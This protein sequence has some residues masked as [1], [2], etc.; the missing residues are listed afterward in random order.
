MADETVKETKAPEMTEE[1]IVGQLPDMQLAQLRFE[2]GCSD[3]VCTNKA[4]LK[5][6]LVDAVT[7]DN[8]TPFYE[9]MCAE[10][11]WS[12]DAALV[13]AA[14]ASNDVE[15][16][17]IDD[18][19][20]DAEENLGDTEVLDALF[21]KCKYFT[22]IGDKDGALASYATILTKADM[23]SEEKG[24]VK[25]STSQRIQIALNKLRLGMFHSDS[26]L[27]KQE[28]PKAKQLVELG[29]DWDRRNRLQVYE[30]VAMMTQRDFKG[31]C[32]LFSKSVATF[33]CTELM[34]FEQLVLYT[35]VTGILSLSRVELQE[36]VVECAEVRSTAGNIPFLNDLMNGIYECR[37]KAFFQA[38]VNIDNSLILNRYLSRH[39]KYIVR[40]FRVLAYSQ[41]LESYRS[42]TLA[43]SAKAF[44]VSIEFLD[45]ELARFIA[46]GRLNAKIDKC[47][48]IVETNRPDA[49]NAQYQA[50]IKQGDLLLNRIQKLAR[51]VNV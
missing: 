7:K 22:R 24:N 44:G 37:Y 2:L 6:Q 48:G 12:V 14:K 51:A 50:M 36:K 1:E 25:L 20:E 9:S 3:S 45:K 27:V 28:L 32:E 42:V 35:V 19:L 11:G 13:A 29:G 43:S 30:G 38:I 17:A 46:S 21:S 39:M 47:A 34:T 49:K 15:L 16:K 41:Y 40:E 18:K 31:A 5:Q 10:F 26:E 8:A 4:E 23:K 33:T